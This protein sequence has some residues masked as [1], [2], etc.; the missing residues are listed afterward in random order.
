M[1]C[2]K[3]YTTHS[4]PSARTDRYTRKEERETLY[5]VHAALGY[6]WSLGLRKPGEEA[7]GSEA[8][9]RSTLWTF[10]PPHQSLLLVQVLPL[11]SLYVARAFRLLSPPW[12]TSTG[13]SKA[14]A[15][16]FSRRLSGAV[17]SRA[18]S[19]T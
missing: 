8:S 10:L 16:S 11:S 15:C 19:P 12:P 1:T 4:N 13:A 14:V 3:F 9:R 7:A 18:D 17:Y 2:H 5:D 6:R